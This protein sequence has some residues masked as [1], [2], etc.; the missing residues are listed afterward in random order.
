[1]SQEQKETPVEKMKRL[2]NERRPNEMQIREMQ[3]R[4]ARVR[5]Q[6]I[7]IYQHEL[8]YTIREDQ[9]IDSH[10]SPNLAR[11][12]IRQVMRSP[13]R[14]FANFRQVRGELDRLKEQCRIYADQQVILF[15]QEGRWNLEAGAGIKLALKEVWYILEHIRKDLGGDIFVAREDLT[16]GFSVE[17]EEYEYL[18]ASWGLEQGQGERQRRSSSDMRHFC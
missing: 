15:Y 8:E 2:A 4:R 17:A 7:Q 10:Q 11:D 1:M 13:S 16:F 18:L 6:L 5:N 9:F 3:L 12:I 14:E